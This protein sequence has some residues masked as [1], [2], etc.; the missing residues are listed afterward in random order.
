MD[1]DTVSDALLDTETVREGERVT[2]GLKLRVGDTLLLPDMLRV[3]EL[4]RVALPHLLSEMVLDNVT[5][6]VD[7]RHRVEVM[8]SVLVPEPVMDGVRVE[9]MVEVEHSVG[10][11]DPEG[12]GVRED[13]TEAEPE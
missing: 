13:E 4:V 2:L 8:D 7:E 10:L 6:E 5:L 1:K 3:T 12:L 11:S 9:E